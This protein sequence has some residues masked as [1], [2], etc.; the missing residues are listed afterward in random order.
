MPIVYFDRLLK[1]INTLIAL[2]LII[3][4]AATFWYVYRP[5]PQTSGTIET[6]VEREVSITRDGLGVPHIAAASLDDALFAQ[7]YAT[8]QDRLWQMDSLRRLAGG[9]LAEIIGPALLDSDRE[10]RGLRLRHL[11]EDAQRTMA[12]ADRAGMAAYT[13][14]V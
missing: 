14:G 4:A 1:Y 3:G 13:R 6:M 2:A 7:G 11:A 12:A 8:A 5:L 10:S 9:E